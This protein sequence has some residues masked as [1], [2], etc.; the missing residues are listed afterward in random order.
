MPSGKVPLTTNYWTPSP[1]TSG[2]YRSSSATFQPMGFRLYLDPGLQKGET[3]SP[4]LTSHLLWLPCS[5]YREHMPTM[6]PASA[7]LHPRAPDIKNLPEERAFS[8]SSCEEDFPGVEEKAVEAKGK[9]V[10]LR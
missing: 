7:D 5:G 6:E 8:P 4:S 3:S 9:T 2:G 1:P 10:S